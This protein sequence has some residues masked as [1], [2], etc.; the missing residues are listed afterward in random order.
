MRTATERLKRAAEHVSAVVMDDG[1]YSYCNE[2]H[3]WCALT[4]RW[5]NL[6][7]SK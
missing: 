5:P 6:K 3:Q 1:D 7:E 4:L 2:F